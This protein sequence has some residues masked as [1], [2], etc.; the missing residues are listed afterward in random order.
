[1]STTVSLTTRELDMHSAP[2]AL[3][4]VRRDL[5][6]LES[7]DVVLDLALVHFLDAAGVGE[8]VRL[9]NELSSVGGRLRFDRWTS[10][11]GRV[12]TITGLLGATE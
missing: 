7:V 2:D 5:A 12:L 11:V 6:A 3:A 1:M 8:V 4:K 10:G 9:R